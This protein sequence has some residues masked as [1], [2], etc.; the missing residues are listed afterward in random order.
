MLIGTFRMMNTC[1]TMGEAAGLMVHVAKKKGK[2][3]NS[4]DYEE[5]LPLLKENKFILKV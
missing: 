5:L 1:M 2:T 3:V 4:V